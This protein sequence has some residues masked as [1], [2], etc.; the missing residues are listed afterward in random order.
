M[1]EFPFMDK[2]LQ[3][4]QARQAEAE[5]NGLVPQQMGPGGAPVRDN[6]VVPPAKQPLPSLPANL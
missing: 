1:T 3:R 6:T 2:I 4:R 5:A